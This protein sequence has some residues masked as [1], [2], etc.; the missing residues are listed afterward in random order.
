[1]SDKLLRTLIREEIKQLIQDDAMFHSRDDFGIV[2]DSDSA[3][4]GISDNFDTPGDN[5][6]MPLSCPVC[7]TEHEGPCHNPARKRQKRDKRSY[8]ARPQLY[9]IAKNAAEIFSMVNK[10]E[11]IDDW[12]E[13]YIAQASQMLDSINKKLSFKESSLD[14]FGKEIKTLSFDHE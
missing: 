8:M 13:S 12:M 5:M 2:D 14:D 3:T 11:Q 7:G 9:G 1:M 6:G 4:Y 10:G